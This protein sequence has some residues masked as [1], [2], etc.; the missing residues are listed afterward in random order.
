MK[1]KFIDHI[2]LIVKNIAETEKFYTSFLGQP[3]FHDDRKLIYEIGETRLFFLLPKGEYEA[4][5]KDKGGLN[6]IAFGVYSLDELKHFEGLLNQAS[7]KH[8][9]IKIDIHGGKDYIWLDDPDNIRIELYCH[10]L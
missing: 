6:H 10:P 2:V 4:K 3:A 8:S 1:I 5:D 9:G 7:I